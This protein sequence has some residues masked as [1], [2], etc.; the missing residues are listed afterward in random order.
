MLKLDNKVK[1]SLL[2]IVKNYVEESDSK[3]IYGGAYGGM[4]GGSE[5][6]DLYSGLNDAYDCD[7]DEYDDD[8]YHPRRPIL[9]THYPLPNVSPKTHKTRRG[10][11]TSA[12]KDKKYEDK[13]WN[14][15]KH[16]LGAISV[17]D[18]SGEDDDADTLDD[19]KL[20]YYY[21]DVHV[22]DD[23]VEFNNLH[24]FSEFLDSEGISI[25]DR[26]SEEICYRTITHCAI[27]PNDRIV[28]GELN[29]VSD[30]S[31]GALYFNCVEYAD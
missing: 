2:G 13:D 21:P 26:E 28:R 19:D 14:R 3:D 20:I 15:V 18:F 6:R 5:Y 12:R 31:Y 25:S 27:D 9:G 16:L 29:L 23:V 10:S 7:W 17:R 24:S 8:V 30:H 1:P 11:G 22:K 4:Y